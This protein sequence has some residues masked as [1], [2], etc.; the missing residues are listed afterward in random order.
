MLRQRG[1]VP[2]AD[3]AAAGPLTRPPTAR[4]T[5]TSSLAERRA[6]IAS[7]WA[8]GA[9]SRAREASGGARQAEHDDAR[10]WAS[11]APRRPRAGRRR[12]GHPRRGR[13]PGEDAAAAGAAPER[14]RTASD[15]A[16]A[17]DGDPRS[18]TRAARASHD[19]DA[20]APRA[21]RGRAPRR[22]GGAGGGAEPYHGAVLDADE[23]ARIAPA[24]AWI[25]RA[26]RAARLFDDR[27]ARMRRDE[28]AGA[29]CRPGGDAACALRCSY[30]GAIVD[31]ALGPCPG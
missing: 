7:D 15:G 19:R 9:V 22:R 3:A 26:R 28:A 25:S 17:T 13:A 11:L 8:D 5:R 24:C 16:E 29:T 27:V 14:Q 18:K 31:Q 12:H 1:A 23:R 2:G 30:G 4:A 21:P 20:R 10:A 6:H